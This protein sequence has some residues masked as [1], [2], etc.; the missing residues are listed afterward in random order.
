MMDALY[1]PDIGDGWRYP[2]CEDLLNRYRLGEW[3]TT[4]DL[5]SVV[6]RNMNWCEKYRPKE[7]EYLLDNQ[8]HHRYLRDW[9]ERQKVAPSK[10]DASFF[11]PRKKVTR[12][13]MEQHYTDDTDMH[14]ND[15]DDF[16]LTGGGSGGNKKK[17]PTKKRKKDLNMILLV[18][19]SGAGKTAGVFTA[20]QETGYQVFEIHPGIRRSLKDVVRLVGDMTKNHLVRFGSIKSSLVSQQ[21]QSNGACGDSDMV[22]DVDD[23][24]GDGDDD[25]ETH[26][27]VPPSKPNQLLTHF[28][29]PK[30]NSDTKPQQ[31]SIPNTGHPSA[32]RDIP[33]KQDQLPMIKSTTTTATATTAV[34]S[35]PKQS[36][37][38]LEEVDLIYQTDKG[39]WNGVT[40]LA[41]TSKR[42]IILTCND[43]SVI[44]FDILQLQAAVYYESPLRQ[45]LLPFLHLVCLM[46]GYLV[47]ASHLVIL[48][49]MIGPDV[50]QLLTTLEYLHHYQGA[51]LFSNDQ[52]HNTAPKLHSSMLQAHMDLLMDQMDFHTLQQSW[53]H[54]SDTIPGAQLAPLC[55]QLIQSDPANK[56]S[57][58]D[59]EAEDSIDDDDDDLFP[60]LQTWLD[61][62][63]L[64]DY[65][66]GMTEKRISQVYGMDE[67]GGKDDQESGYMHSWKTHDDWDH[68]EMEA[69]MESDLLELNQPQQGTGLVDIMSW[70]MI[71]DQRNKQYV[72]DLMS[73][74]HMLNCRSNMALGSFGILDITYSKHIEHLRRTTSRKRR[75]KMHRVLY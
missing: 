42:P 52:Q 54:L 72:D 51:T 12:R 22:D 32:P 53:Y 61:N 46:E 43:T 14:D 24:E 15:D 19:P 9:L 27:V 64:I 55:M 18:G 35:G 45:L 1:P 20:A 57:I 75:R 30:T 8:S 25:S 47:P 33:A 36:L 66:I 13:T 60:L 49:D 69:Y 59:I 41:R 62:R 23:G 40:D 56:Q 31:K 65:G 37:I 29:T 58:V 6:D 3:K 50:R 70:E 63:S 68:Y 39:F 21:R 7:V 73:V 71:C 48:V 74:E 26:R 2:A 4:M 11:G 28:F 5:S 38:L 10:T 67:H 34:P 17:K 44:P 16:M